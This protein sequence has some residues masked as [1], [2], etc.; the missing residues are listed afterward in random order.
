MSM[1]NFMNYS[2][3]TAAEG[4]VLSHAPLKNNK[5][6]NS[7]QSTQPRRGKNKS[8]SQDITPS[9]R[10][11]ACGT[12]RGSW[13]RASIL[14]VMPNEAPDRS[15]G[16]RCHDLSFL[17]DELQASFFTLLFHIY[18]KALQFLFIF[19]HKGGVICIS[20][21]IDIYLDSLDCCLQSSSLAFCM[22]YPAYKLNKE[23]DNIQPCPYPFPVFN[24]SVVA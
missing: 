21:V 12:R 15:H 9:S 4:F 23:G 1:T 2:L 11:H 17:N 3:S 24:Q 18:Q 22:I 19:C 5:N 8:E 16:T 13:G 6:L 10:A 20:E 14:S 7:F